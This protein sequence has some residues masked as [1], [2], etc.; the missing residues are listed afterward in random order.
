MLPDP[1]KNWAKSLGLLGV[2]TA[3]LLGFTGIGIGLGYWLWKKLG[4]PWWVLIFCTMA[5]LVLAFYRLYE[6]SKKDMND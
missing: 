2:I 1:K 5:G 4:M 6:I 3:D